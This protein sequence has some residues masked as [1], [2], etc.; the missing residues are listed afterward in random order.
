MVSVINDIA[1]QWDLKIFEALASL[2]LF[3]YKKLEVEYLVTL[4]NW[5]PKVDRLDAFHGL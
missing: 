3:A 2:Y 4:S 5:R 1:D